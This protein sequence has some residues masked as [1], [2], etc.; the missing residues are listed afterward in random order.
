MLQAGEPKKCFFL[1]CGSRRHGSVSVSQF[2]AITSL[3][4]NSFKEFELVMFLVFLDVFSGDRRTSKSEQEN[5]LTLI[6]RVDMKSDLFPRPYVFIHRV[7]LT[8]CCANGNLFKSV[9]YSSALDK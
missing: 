6:F 8:N 2:S 9:E 5:L 1:E 4:T 3:L 7:E